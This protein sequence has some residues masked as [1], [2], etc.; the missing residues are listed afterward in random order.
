[1]LLQAGSDRAARDTRGH[2]AYDKAIQYENA[3][4]ADLLI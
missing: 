2:T 4:I 3:E 1:L